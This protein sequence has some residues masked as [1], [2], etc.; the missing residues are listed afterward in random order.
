M[1]R[2]S[3]LSILKEIMKNEQER[4][5]YFCAD[6][7]GSFREITWIIT[8]RYKLKDANII[9]L[10]DVGLGF[11]KPGYYNQ[12]FERINTR[13]EKNNIT[14][15]FIRGNHDNLEYWNEKLINDYPRTLGENNISD[16]GSNFSR[17]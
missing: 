13:L 7:H 11:S 4:D 6:I 2:E 9:F 14:Y 17:L 10:G 8:Q 16:R 1:E 3:K 15:Y 12:E 5:L